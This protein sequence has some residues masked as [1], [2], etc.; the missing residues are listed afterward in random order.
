MILCISKMH[1]KSNFSRAPEIQKQRMDGFLAIVFEGRL[2]MNK[3]NGE[4]LI[5]AGHKA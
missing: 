2:D 5:L 4:K 3:A 1:C